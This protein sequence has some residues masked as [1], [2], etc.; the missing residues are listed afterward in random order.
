MW[1]YI[2]WKET[3]FWA[4][5]PVLELALRVPL[6][7]GEGPAERRMGRWYARLGAV[8][9]RRWTGPL[10]RAAC[11]ACALARERARPFWPWRAELR[12]GPVWEADGV[13][14]L[15]TEGVERRGR[16]EPR[17]V[18]TAMI[19]EARSGCPLRA[20]E[21]FGAEAGWRK[22]INE[23]VEEGLSRCRREGIALWRDAE[24]RAVR[25]CDLRNLYL[26]ADGPVL[27]Y[28][29]GVLGPP[30]SGILEFPLTLG[31][32]TASEKESCPK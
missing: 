15:W 6:P 7:V 11:G 22:R 16:E 30:G 27:F 17:V 1:E 12:S 13:S 5:E 4:E 10:Y 25:K 31:G 18:R 28:P 19:W 21:L 14:S 8:W 24:R 29:M 20:A 26:T 9:Y 32:D 2:C 23:Q 3:L